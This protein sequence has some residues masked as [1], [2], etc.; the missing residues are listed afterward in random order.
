[1]HDVHF[2][3]R[4]LRAFVK[5]Y[6]LGTIQAASKAVHISQPAVTQGLARLENELNTTLFDRQPHGM[7]PTAAASLLYPRARDA[8]E[9]IRSNRVSQAQIRAFAAL[10]RDG[11]YADASAE[12]GLARASL[13]RAVSDLEATLGQSLIRRR[14]RG[15]ELTSTGQ[16]T[17]RRYRLAMAELRASVDELRS[18]RGEGAGRLS[19]G[20]MPLCRARVLP[21]SIVAFQREVVDC[22]VLVAEGSHVELIEPLRDG[23]LD[24]LIGALRDPPP[25]PDL[26]QMPLFTDRP[27]FLARRDHPLKAHKSGANL[28]D[29]GRFDW[30]IPPK[31]VP[32]RDRWEAMFDEAGVEVP[33][34][35]VECGSVIA[36]RQI[37]MNTD[38]LTILSRDQVAVELE[39]GWL[40][41]VGTAPE[42]LTRTIGITHR[43]GWR[44][45][46]LQ[47]LFLATLENVCA[48]SG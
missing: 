1:M 2:N 17:A 19:I 43:T 45:T 3:L 35:Q 21:A 27:V 47:S 15:I 5:T 16:T 42:S 25:G 36:I 6:E 44:P 38:C 31:G 10:A 12:T 24:F 32:L 28:S 14:G 30:C 41:I 18:L 4:H 26:V 8:L 23:E 20:A 39:A 40:K 46:Q 9:L 22:Q 7:R 48:N 33:R 37:L 11:S 29:L 13:H 34:V